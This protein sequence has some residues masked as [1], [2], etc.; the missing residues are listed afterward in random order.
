MQ[1]P[2]VPHIKQGSSRVIGKSVSS[3]S[4]NLDKLRYDESKS[5]MLSPKFPL[6][7]DLAGFKH[8]KEQNFAKRKSSLAQESTNLTEKSREVLLITPGSRQ[9][10][11]AGT[12]SDSNQKCGDAKVLAPDVLT[13]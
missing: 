2:I 8:A 5:T 6:A 12:E 11:K 10:S 7:P 1:N 9:C 3:K 4:F 13:A